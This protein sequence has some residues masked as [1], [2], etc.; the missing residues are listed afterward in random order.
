MSWLSLLPV[1][2]EGVWAVRGR[3]VTDDRGEFA[4]LFCAGELREAFGE[5]RV[6]QCNLSLTLSPGAIRGLHFQYPPRAELKMV[7]CL[8]GRVWDVA[9]DLRAGSATFLR[10]HAQELTAD[11]ICA[12]IIPE[13]CAHG[14]QVLEAGSQLLYLHTADYSPEAEGGVRYDEP[15]ISIE[16]PLAVTDISARDRLHQPL[17]RDFQGISI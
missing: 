13:G 9:V 2:I 16:W 5:R 7:R 14:F 10:W 11:G 4:R 6:R 15:M 8:K 17:P 1:P 12:L 3:V